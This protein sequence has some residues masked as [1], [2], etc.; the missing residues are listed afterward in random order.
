MIY[1]LISL[2]CFGVILYKYFCRIL[3]V[4]STEHE[5]PLINLITV[6]FNIGG[7]FLITWAIQVG[8]NLILGDMFGNGVYVLSFLQVMFIRL[9]LMA[10]TLQASGD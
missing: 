5:D 3:L 4:A 1:F 6:T 9:L 10:S 2:I 8:V 7:F